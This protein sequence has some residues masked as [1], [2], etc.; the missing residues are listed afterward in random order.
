MEKDY[1]EKDVQE[2]L[3]AEGLFAAYEEAVKLKDS[4]KIQTLL[5]KISI[6][7]DTIVAILEDLDTDISS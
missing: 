7:D 4:L 6:E 2:R 1:S 5:Q 3:K